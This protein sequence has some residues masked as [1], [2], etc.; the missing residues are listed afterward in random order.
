MFSAAMNL[1]TTM[2]MTNR[3]PMITKIISAAIPVAG[4]VIPAVLLATTTASASG[5]IEVRGDQAQYSADGKRAE[6]EGNVVVT[7]GEAVVRAGRLIVSVFTEGNHYQISGTPAQAECATCTDVLLQLSAPEILM[8]DDND[9]LSVQGGLTLCAGEGCAN[10]EIS[11]TSAQWQ[12]AAGE[13]SL[14]GDPIRGFWRGADDGGE[15]TVR[16][17]Q[18]EYQQDSGQ[19][20]LSGGAV[21]SRGEEEIRGETIEL[22]IKTGSVA[23]QG[24]GGD[25]SRV[26]GVFGA[27]E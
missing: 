1:G 18:I 12:R 24:G 7:S 22:N 9:T 14:Q 13:V 26:R 16:A 19:V 15:V 25:S 21:I 4:C 5:R 8:R 6:F 10:G 23:A 11:A 20:L 2:T 3:Q 17:E 27:D